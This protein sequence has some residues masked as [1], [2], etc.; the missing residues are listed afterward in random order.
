MHA[1][2]TTLITREG[3]KRIEAA[4]DRYV[5]ALRESNVLRCAKPRCGDRPDYTKRVADAERRAKEAFAEWIM[6]F[7]HETGSK[8]TA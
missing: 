1:S 4:R 6:L 8:I 5:T 3:A 2:I 7:E